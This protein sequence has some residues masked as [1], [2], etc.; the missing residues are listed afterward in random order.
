MTVTLKHMRQVVMDIEGNT[1]LRFVGVPVGKAL[2]IG[3]D[4]IK[5]LKDS[6]RPSVVSAKGLAEAVC[7]G[8]R[9]HGRTYRSVSGP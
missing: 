6:G 4:R 9:V 2:L 7:V 8:P 5:V 1:Y 3:G